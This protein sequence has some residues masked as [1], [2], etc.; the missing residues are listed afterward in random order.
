MSTDPRDLQQRFDELRQWLR[1]HGDYDVQLDLWSVYG[2]YR[3]TVSHLGR[4]LWTNIGEN[5]DKRLGL[6]LAYLREREGSDV[7]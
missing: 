4:E 1:M 6:A 3:V 5:L 7:G 2:C